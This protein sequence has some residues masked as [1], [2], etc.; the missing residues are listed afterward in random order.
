MKSPTRSNSGNAGPTATEL[1]LRSA[2]LRASRRMMRPV[3]SWFVHGTEAGT[4]IK[5]FVMAPLAENRSADSSCPVPFA[6]IF[7]FPFHPNQN[8][9]LPPSR[10]TEGR[11]AIVTDVGRGMRFSAHHGLK[12]DIARGPKSADT[13]EKVENR[14]GVKISRMLNMGAL[15]PARPCR[16]DTSVGGRSCVDRCG[17]SRRSA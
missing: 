2:P 5:T 10:P 6:K 15:S 16:T 3:P 14:G 1:I 13:V 11:F 9:G 17:P 8:L 12:L 7:P 4:V